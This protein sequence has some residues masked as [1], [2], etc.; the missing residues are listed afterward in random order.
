[1]LSLAA[2]E[3]W[4]FNV[5]ANERHLKASPC[6][7]TVTYSQAVLYSKY[8]GELHTSRVRMF[9]REKSQDVGKYVTWLEAL[10]SKCEVKKEEY[11]KKKRA[12]IVDRK[13]TRVML[14]CV[15][16]IACCLGTLPLEF[17]RARKDR[18]RHVMICSMHTSR[19]CALTARL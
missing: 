7:S 2:T 17:S 8:L 4:V 19:R 15:T 12:G 1:M 11:Y 6:C 18:L 13:G 3:T 5:G 10:R 9:T 14:S 16:Q